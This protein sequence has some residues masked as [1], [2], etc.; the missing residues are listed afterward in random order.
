MSIKTKGSD[1]PISD[2][3]VI[4]TEGNSLTEARNKLTSLIPKGLEV[5]K[6]SIISDGKIKTVKSVGSSKDDAFLKAQAKLPPD[7]EIL[8]KDVLSE[9]EDKEWIF[10]AIDEEAANAAAK[11]DI[12]GRFGANSRIKNVSLIAPAKKG[13]L[14]VGKKPAQ[15]KV[16]IIT[17]AVVKISYKSKSRISA[18]VGRRL[19]GWQELIAFLKKSD[20]PLD[21]SIFL[22]Y[23]H[24]ILFALISDQMNNPSYFE[25][26]PFGV[27]TDKMV[28]DAERFISNPPMPKD[29]IESKYYQKYVRS[30]GGGVDKVSDG[31]VDLYLQTGINLKD[32]GN[33][34]ISNGP[35][36]ARRAFA[37][38]KHYSNIPIV[39]YF[40]V[41]PYFDRAILSKTFSSQDA[42]INVYKGIEGV[43]LSL[44]DKLKEGEYISN[45]RM[46]AEVHKYLF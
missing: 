5:L 14:G 34:D 31:Y 28:K 35:E 4:E 10:A 21:E 43:M 13:I 12:A 1:F 30:S 39:K 7:A 27:V 46:I 44:W 40:F 29:N 9:P 11:S 42:L 20:N 32:K 26:I 19:K 6:E 22:A 23:P 33:F 17:P 18:V 3:K 16:D 38:V 36:M 24:Q 2:F 8:K 15:F 41:L 45:Q 37:A 25:S